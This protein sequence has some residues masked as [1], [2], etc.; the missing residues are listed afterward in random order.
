MH[1]NDKQ[2]NYFL[3]ATIPLSITKKKIATICPQ[4]PPDVGSTSWCSS[5]SAKTVA[6]Y[7]KA[8]YENNKIHIEGFNNIISKV[9]E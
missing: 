1:I 7:I 8:K 3:P 5:C 9:N 6:G 2:Y 4:N